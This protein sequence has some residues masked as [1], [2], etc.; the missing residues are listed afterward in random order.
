RP[1]SLLLLPRL[2]DGGKVLFEILNGIVANFVLLQKSVQLEQRGDAQQRAE[3]VA[4]QAP[5]AI[6]LQANSFQCGTRKISP[7][8]S[9]NGG[10]FVRDFERDLHGYSLARFTRKP[11]SY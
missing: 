9:K 8:A 7:R 2:A 10:Q 11:E 5:L 4:A 1:I 3:L 6:G